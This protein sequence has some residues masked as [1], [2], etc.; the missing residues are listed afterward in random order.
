[1]TFLSAVLTTAHRNVELAIQSLPPS[2]PSSPTSSTSSFSHSNRSPLPSPHAGEESAEPLT[3]PVPSQAQSIGEDAR[4]LLQKT[5]DVVSKPLGAISRIFSEALDEKMSFLPGPF[6]PFELARERTQEGSENHTEQHWAHPDQIAQFRTGSKSKEQEEPKPPIQTT[7][8]PRVRRPSPVPPSPGATSAEDTKTS[9]KAM[10]GASLW[11]DGRTG[12][13]SP[14]PQHLL[15]PLQQHISR[16]PTPS[17][18]LTAVQAEIDRAHAHASAASQST[19][20]QIF[21]GVDA[22]V[23]EWV[24]EANGGDLGKSIEALLEMTGDS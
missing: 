21:P 4:R 13:L 17:L 18:D 15:P 10:F 3:L 16:T 1:M 19:L 6:A 7:Y 5:G 23:R 9:A 14:L 2:V 24:L 12:T 20:A 22:E 8:K 11:Q